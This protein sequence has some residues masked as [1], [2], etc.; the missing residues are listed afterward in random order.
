MLPSDRTALAQRL[1]DYFELQLRFAAR[2]CQHT[3][4]PLREGV[5]TFTNL[6]RRFGFGDPEQ[7]LHPDWTRYVEGL[8][9]QRDLAAQRAWT[10]AFHAGLPGEP[11]TPPGQALFGCFSCDPPDAEGVLRLHFINRDQDELSPL[12]DAKLG[13][14]RQDLARL[15]AFVREQASHAKAVRGLSWLYHLPAYRRL[16]P[17]AYGESAA[18]A[19]AVRL[20]GSSSWGQFL[21]HDGSVRVALR[22]AFLQS[23]DRVD[24]QAPWRSFPLPALMVE[25]PIGL[26]QRFY[27]A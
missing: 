3:G 20:N 22:A 21:R 12:A 5:A 18:P 4:Q 10:Q 1:G 13:R 14:R 16:F 23:L 19:G 6:H 17:P 25:A 9:R 7:G 27:A 11:P 26:F 2:L 15:F 8:E 24:P